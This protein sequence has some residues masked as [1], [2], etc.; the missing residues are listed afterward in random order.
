MSASL[1]LLW[2]VMK[3]EARVLSADRSL[4][5]VGTLL[6]LLAAYA[7]FNG[8]S[9]TREREALLASI[10]KQQADRVPAMRAQLQRVLSGAEKPD[11]F[12]NPADPA[13]IGS[14]GGGRH[15]TMPYL[16][17]AP[18]AFGQSDMLPNYYRMTYRSKASFMDE[19][20]LEN[21][22]NLLSGRFDLAFV[23]VVLMPLAILALC[24]NLLSGEREQGTLRL[25]L[26]Q[27]ISVRTLVA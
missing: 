26:A 17:L 4:W 25:L 1:A 5:I 6:T 14:G 24:Y 7:L 12:A 19:G 11:P 3:H 10:H 18:I 27:P 20:E 21:P 13:S 15:A 22:W 9:D 23:I 8:L 2:R 16:A